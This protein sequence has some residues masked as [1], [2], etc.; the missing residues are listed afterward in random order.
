MSIACGH[1]EDAYNYFVRL[2]DGTE[3]AVLKSILSAKPTWPELAAAA[4]ASFYRIED[5]TGLTVGAAAP[6][7]VSEP[8]SEPDVVLPPAPVVEPVVEAVVAAEPIAEP[9]APVEGQS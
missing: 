4:G 6:E 8:D 7:P 9:V 5:A 1:G 3:V 2:T